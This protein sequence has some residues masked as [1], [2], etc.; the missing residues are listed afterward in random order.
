MLS[1]QHLHQFRRHID[2]GLLQRSRTN[3][4]CGRRARLGD[5]R[6]PA[7][8]AF[9]EIRVADGPQTRLVGE[10]RQSDRPDGRLAAIAIIGV[11]QALDVDGETLDKDTLI[12]A[13]GVPGIAIASR[14]LPGCDDRLP[15]VHE[16]GRQFGDIRRAH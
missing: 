10:G 8:D 3:V 5:D 12:L 15:I 6:S 9:N 2:I 14:H 16:V 13:G 7:I 11:D 4:A 1:L